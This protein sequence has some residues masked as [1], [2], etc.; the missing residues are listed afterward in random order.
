MTDHDDASRWRDLDDQVRQWWDE[1]L[2]TADES[3]VRAD[4]NALYL[5]EP[6]ASGGGRVGP[7]WY[8]SMF[9]WDTWFSNLALLVHERTDLVRAHVVNYVSMVERFGFMPNA[10]QVALRTRSQTP[11]FPDG[12]LRLVRATGDTA[13]LHR[14]YAAMVT[15]YTGYWCAEHHRT[16]SGLATNADLGDPQLDPRLAAEAETGLD[17][18]PLYDG[19]VRRVAPLLTNCALVRYAEVL[20]EC[21]ALLGKEADAA[22]W[23]ARAQERAALIRE[24]CWDEEEGFFFDYDHVAGRRLPHWS[25]CGF[26]PLWAGVAT[27][28][29]AR[30]A[31]TALDRFR[32]PYGLTT[33]DRAL[34]SPHPGMADGDVQWMHPAGW[35]PLIIMTAWGL[36]RYGLAERAREASEG[37]VALMVRHFE[38]TGELYEKYN[39]VSGGLALPNERYGTIRL[40][41]WTSAAAVLLGRLVHEGTPLDTLLM[42][43]ESRLRASAGAGEG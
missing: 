22:E 39:V 32:T 6:Y 24:L 10:N 29:Q 43:S 25:L 16:P 23:R 42:E 30:R 15:E 8:R 33:T 35:A 2:V 13:L 3:E 9:A 19:D 12:I 14:A 28:E 21:A 20:A 7:P 17:W 36:D 26:W 4:P 27:P 11:V 40:H 18:T 1:D 38:E 5:P 34:P 37:F 41:G 31:A